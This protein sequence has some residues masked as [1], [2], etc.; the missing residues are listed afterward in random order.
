MVLGGRSHD[1]VVSKLV[2][3]SKMVTGSSEKPPKGSGLRDE[4]VTDESARVSC[5]H[6]RVRAANPTTLNQQCV[7][8][9]GEGPDGVALSASTC[10]PAG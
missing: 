4:L 1:D 6:M 10:S 8:G 7:R 2:R 5:H 3:R 9:G